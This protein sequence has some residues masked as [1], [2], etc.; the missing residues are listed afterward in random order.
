MASLPQAIIESLGRFTLQ[1]GKNVAAIVPD[2]PTQRSAH[3]VYFEDGDSNVADIVA[4]TIPARPAAMLLGDLVPKAASILGDVP[5][6]STASVALA[7]RREDVDHPLNGSGFLV[8][9]GE[10]SPFTGCTWSSSKW[11]G[12]APSGWVLLRAFVGN[13]GN[14]TFADRDDADLV[15]MVAEGLRPLLGLRGEPSRVWVHRWPGAMPQYRVGHGDSMDELE[16]AMAGH[17]GLFLAGASYRGIGVPDCIR[18]AQETADRIVRTISQRDDAPGR[19]EQRTGGDL[20]SK[21][22]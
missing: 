20:F 14:E 22:G 11:E 4:V 1:T 7:Y 13:A 17:P 6:V 5:S 3:R 8:P 21:Q 15:G 10:P 12:R 9:R 19:H 2:G 18:Q 16:R